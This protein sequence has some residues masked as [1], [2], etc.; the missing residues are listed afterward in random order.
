MIYDFLL[1]AAALDW[2]GHRK[3]GAKQFEILRRS[4]LLA[5]GPAIGCV[6]LRYQWGRGSI[7]ADAFRRQNLPG[8]VIL[9][10]DTVAERCGQHNWSFYSAAHAAL[11]H[12]P[13]ATDQRERALL[14]LWLTYW[15]R[16]VSAAFLRS[17]LDHGRRS[18]F[19]PRT[20]RETEILF[21]ALLV[22]SALGILEEHLLKNLQAV[23]IPLN[24][25]LSILGGW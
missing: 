12:V 18:S 1:A 5:V 6:P 7:V 2:L 16:Q 19:L 4:A 14:E 23:H 8:G 13:T 15:H 11:P 20:E 17:Y 10:G 24:G 9:P 21:D 22:Q 25:L 3:R